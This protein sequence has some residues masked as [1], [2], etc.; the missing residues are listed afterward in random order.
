MRREAQRI[1]AT[2]TLKP[3]ERIMD[4]EAEYW[5]GFLSKIKFPREGI[6]FLVPDEESGPRCFTLVHEGSPRTLPIM[7]SPGE[8][9]E[10]CRDVFAAALNVPGRKKAEVLLPARSFSQEDAAADADTII[11]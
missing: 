8:T 11:G 4:A 1:E 7:L 5:A 6:F 10:H 9:L 3:I 2:Q